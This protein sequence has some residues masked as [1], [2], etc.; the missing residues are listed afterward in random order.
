[1]VKTNNLKDHTFNLDKKQYLSKLRLHSKL[2][3][4]LL[5]VNEIAVQN[6]W[7]EILTLKGS[8]SVVE[9][10]EFRH[11]NTYCNYDYVVNRIS[12]KWEEHSPIFARDIISNVRNK[13]NKLILK[14]I[15]IAD[16]IYQNYNS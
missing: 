16:R 2:N 15:L 5:E 14:E 4:R 8:D 7:M 12:N 3:I 9:L 10:G 6:K 11:Y 13:V 1:M